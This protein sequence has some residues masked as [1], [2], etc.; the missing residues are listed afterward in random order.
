MQFHL[1]K[2]LH[3]LKGVY[4]GFQQT[5]IE[6][7]IE[8]RNTNPPLV[9]PLISSVKYFMDFVSSE[10]TNW[11]QNVEY[12]LVSESPL[13]SR[14]GGWFYSRMSGWPARIRLLCLM[15][16]Q[17][18]S[19]KYNAH[20]EETINLNSLKAVCSWPA[21]NISLPGDYISTRYLEAHW[22]LL[23]WE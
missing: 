21:I 4:H 6:I 15:F 17:N 22:V 3:T 14:I 2:P 16:L 5:E 19:I 10:S 23:I 13:F 9:F 11:I 8:G 20:H 12:N 1:K 7:E 18:L